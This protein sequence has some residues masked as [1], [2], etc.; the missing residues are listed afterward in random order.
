M[1][2]RT[3]LALERID[4]S[5]EKL[6]IGVKQ[7]RHK[8]GALSVT[9]IDVEN[10]VGAQSVGKP[11]G[12]YITI[13]TKGFQTVSPCFAE[14][15]VTVSELLSGMFPKRM[16][17]VL[18]IGLGNS[19]ITPDALGPQVVRY[20]LATRHISES[21]AKE[22][23]LSGLRPVCALAPG[24]LGQTGIETAEIVRAICDQIS[25][26]LVIVIDALA[27]KSVD[28]L[29]NTIQIANTGISPGSGV[30]NHRRELSQQ[31]LGVP[32]LSIGV[33]TVVDLHSIAEDFSVPGIPYSERVDNMMVTPRE[34]D[35]LIEHAA[36]TVAYA[37]G[38]SLQPSLSIEDI[39][40]LTA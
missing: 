37:I 29:G 6:P 21:L 20:T 34:I 2:I 33:P 40:A 11:M 16:N 26:D 30:M 1:G 28:R 13:E 35:E 18:I 24:V 3:D 5:V 39:A 23:G 19:S 25:P 17:S 36:K 15:V 4:F 22:I 31:T 32:V 12:R 14:D 7:S 9:I 27:S 8:K 38:K 10:D